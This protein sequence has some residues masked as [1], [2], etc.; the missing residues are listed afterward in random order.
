MIPAFTFVLDMINT[1]KD[2]ITNEN[3]SRIQSN[4]AFALGT[5][6]QDFKLHYLGKILE[7][8]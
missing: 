1:D 4:L 8:T 7:F 3:M 5:H 2:F 6:D